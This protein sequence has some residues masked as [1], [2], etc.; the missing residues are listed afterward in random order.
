M[1][2][3]RLTIRNIR[4]IS[5]FDLSLKDD[6]CPGWHVL[7]GENGSGKSTLV[8]ALAT[9]LMG[10]TNAHASRQDWSDWLREGERTG[11]VEVV[12]RHHAGDRWVKKGKTGRRPFLAR[13]ELSRNGDSSE[14]NGTSSA[15]IN[16]PTRGHAHRTVWGDGDGWFS[17][18][19]GP[20]RRFGGG[21]PEVERLYFSHPRLAPHLSALGEH[22]ASGESLRW[23]R[24]LQTRALEGDEEAGRTKEAVVEFINEA[25]LFPYEARIAEVT[26]TQVTMV[27]GQGARVAIEEM[28]DGYRSILSMTLELL[29]LMSHISPARLTPGERNGTIDL[30]GVVAIDEVDAHLHPK[31]QQRIG[32]WFVRRFPETQFFVT[33]HSPIICR[34]ATSVW[35][36]PPPG[37]SESFRR[38]T[39]PEYDRLVDGNI[40]DAYSTNLFGD[41]VTRSP[42]S[43]QKVERLAELSQKQLH[44]EL[45]P[46]EEEE[47]CSLRSAMPSTPTGTTRLRHGAQ[48]D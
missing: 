31:W 48:T 25:E 19:F 4:S 33:T 1:H 8:R 13:A 24:E 42:Q 10:A 30:P 32:G 11:S 45:T 3:R 46:Q 37:S 36:L 35:K 28:S 44:E 22:V 27:D 40:L 12:I 34:A 21:D 43:E 9:V 18:S 6:E 17:A 7:L 39:D 15:K 20:F 38:A 26:S 29:R 41:D 2:I 16:F 5:E 14:A 47:L 23:L